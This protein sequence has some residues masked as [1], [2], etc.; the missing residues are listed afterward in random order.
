MQIKINEWNIN[1]EVLGDGNPVILLHGWLANLETMRPI[2]NNLC[3]NFKVYLVD[4]VGFGKSDLPEHPLKT[5]DFGDFLKQFIEK[6]NIKNPILIG[7][8]NGGRMIINAVGRGIVSAKKIVLIDSAGLKPRRSINYYL[9][10]GFYKVGKFILN[11]LPNTKTVKNFK[12]KL[13]NRVGSS[14]YKQSAVVLKET[15]KIILNEDLSYLLPKISV[16]T[17][18]FWGSLDNATPIEDGRKMEKLIP[19]CGLI[20]YKGSSHFSYLENINNVNSVLNEF[21]KDDK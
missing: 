15:M 19:D 12:E 16:P 4:V 2:A 14:D 9:K 13:R 11:L 18:L 20:E 8:S 6:L 5:D 17:L 1:Y 3:K 21:F 7:H 10:V